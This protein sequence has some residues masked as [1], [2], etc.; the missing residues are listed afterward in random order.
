MQRGTL[1][2]VQPASRRR[3]LKASQLGTV[4]PRTVN[5]LGLLSAVTGSVPCGA[6]ND[7]QLA[8]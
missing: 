1:A 4:T 3:T 2:S 5:F 6:D 8:A 7:S